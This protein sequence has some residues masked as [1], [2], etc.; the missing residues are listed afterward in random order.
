M[1]PQKPDNTTAGAPAAETTPHITVEGFDSRVPVVID[2][3]SPRD[4]V[5]LVIETQAGLER[6]AAAIA[7][8]TTTAGDESCAPIVRK[9]QTPV[10][11][12]NKIKSSATF[13][14][15]HAASAGPED[16]VARNTG[17]TKTAVAEWQRARL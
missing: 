11:H 15:G 7:A 9:V 1:T 5:P 13:A 3:D 17:W 2:L 8:G 14:R 4:G 12:F 10:N 16:A 6:C